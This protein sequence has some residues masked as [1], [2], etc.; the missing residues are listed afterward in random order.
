MLEPNDLDHTYFGE[1]VADNGL[2]EAYNE[3][4][5]NYFLPLA[6]WLGKRRVG[7]RTL[8]LGIN[9]AQGTGKSTL[10]EFLGLACR[11]L[12]DW[13]PVV[14][15]IDDFYLTRAEREALAENRH[16]LLQTRGVPGTHDT[17]LLRD[18]LEAITGLGAGEVTTYPRFD[19]SMDDR[20]A[21]PWPSVSGPVD[22]LILEGWCV[23]T[24]P[25]S[26]AAL[27]EPVNSLER[28]RDPDAAWRRWVNE[29]LRVDYAKLWSRLDAL[30]FL[31]AP[32]FD[33]IH[34]WRLKQEHK[35]ALRV[36][37]DAEGVMSDAEVRDFISYY[38]RLTRH[39]LA[40]LGDTADVIFD[41]DENHA[42]AYESYR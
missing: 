5:D 11:M 26:T 13:N 28:E 22:L 32:G 16:P 7:K 12:H 29:R 6:K 35:L 39:N 4:I 41:L 37:S 34:A 27:A 20:A 30:V 24:S 17:T 42:V 9:G 38:E 3:A 14:M 2:P 1:F 18:T 33:A 23:G 31:R 25:E 10:G 15:S 40:T 36:G 21:P 8:V 19:K